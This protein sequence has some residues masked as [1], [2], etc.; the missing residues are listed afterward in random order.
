MENSNYK[1]LGVIFLIEFAITSLLFIVFGLL[2]ALN[3][4][5]FAFQETNKSGVLPAVLVY[6]LVIFIYVLLMMTFGLAGWKLFKNKSGAKGWGIAAS[7]CSLFFFFP[8]GI[9]I[10]VVGFVLLFTGNANTNSQY[11]NQNPQY[12]NPPNPPQNWH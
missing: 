10:S 5:L 4:G 7:V 11:Q 8:L 1:V 9:I 2:F 12:Y 3:V 6:G